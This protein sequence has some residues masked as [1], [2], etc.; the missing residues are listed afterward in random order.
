MYNQITW[1]PWDECATQIKTEDIFYYPT[2]G[3]YLE[4]FH[5]GEVFVHPR[6]ITLHPSFAQDF[7]TTFMEGCPLFLNKSYAKELGFEDQVVSPLMLL[8]IALSLGVQ[9]ESEKAIAHLG[10]YNVCFPKITYVGETMRSITRVLDRKEKAQ[11]EPGIVHVQTLGLNTKKEVLVRYERKIMIPSRPE[12]EKKTESHKTSQK[13]DFPWFQSTDIT[14]PERC[15]QVLDGQMLG[16]WTTGKT[17]FEDF[18][19]GQIIIH[20][21]GRTITDEHIPWTYRLGNTHPLHYDSIYTQALSAPMGGSPVVYGG[22]V[23]SWIAGLASRDTTENMIWDLGYTQGYHT[24]PVRSGDTLYAISRILKKEESIL[25]HAG[26]I[27]IQL[28]G[29]KNISS[30]QAIQKFGKE[31]FIKEN[32]KKTLGLEKITNKIFEIERKVLIRK[33]LK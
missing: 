26:I 1:K 3:R 8:S 2:Y 13:V 25:S 30:S 12:T 11:G 6:G 32:N 9:N 19:A 18:K 15:C 24:Q 31:L 16:D 4:E 5:P 20:H 27:T 29:L 21:N 33:L 10:Y 22:L 14:L 7:A 23:F 17:Y 28:I